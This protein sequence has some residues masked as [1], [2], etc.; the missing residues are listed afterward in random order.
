V[1][2]AD[3]SQQPAQRSTAMSIRQGSRAN[4]P[5]HRAKALCSSLE[6]GVTEERRQRQRRTDGRRGR[7]NSRVDV[8]RHEE[9]RGGGT[10]ISG[11]PIQSISP[12][13]SGHRRRRDGGGLGPVHGSVC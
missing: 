11:T 8:G 6:A 1:E 7:P 2:L 9:S 5:W 4:V 13:L 3:A 12:L 10:E